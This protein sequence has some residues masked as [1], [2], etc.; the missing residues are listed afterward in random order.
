M[1]LDSFP[2][3]P[4]AMEFAGKKP[5]AIEKSRN[6]KMNDLANKY[7]VSEDD[8]LAF[9]I[10][11]DGKT[12]SYIEGWRTGFDTP[13]AFVVVE[14][15]VNGK[16]VQFQMENTENADASAEMQKTFEGRIGNADVSSN[17]AKALFNRFCE[18]V[19]ERDSLGRI[20]QGAAID[21]SELDAIEAIL[22][23]DKA[24]ALKAMDGDTI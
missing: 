6:E 12:T 2:T 19:E 13:G 7:K 15:N 20:S 16:H 17:A 8:L 4:S 14:G 22:G 24:L 11:K 1:G 21:A 9:T 3:K 10:K 5:E 18:M 23:G